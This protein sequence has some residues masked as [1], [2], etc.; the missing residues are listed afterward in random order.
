MATTGQMSGAFGK[1]E[2]RTPAGTGTYSDI[3]G[4][5][6]AVEVATITRTNGK[7]YPLDSDYPIL[8]FGKQEGAEVTFMVIYTEA[9]AEAYQT[10][11]TSFEASGGN[12]VDVKWTP[13]GATAG[14]DTYTITGKIISIDYP[15]FN[16]DSGD[17]IMCNF[18]VAGST[19][20][21]TV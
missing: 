1:I 18:V 4:S 3:S 14:A 20:V 21:H 7:A 2:I 13:G 19:I 9:V 12:T 15:A 10:A 6:Q 8:T 5:S 16:G 11:L 17:T